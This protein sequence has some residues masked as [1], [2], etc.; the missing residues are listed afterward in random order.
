MHFSEDDL[1]KAL[2]RQDPGSAFT[3]RVMAGIDRAETKAQA[4]FRPY[5]FFSRMFPL[6]MRP[7]LGGA[8]AALVLLTGGGA[9]YW[10][11]QQNERKKQQE[12][13]IAKQA[14]RQAVLA[15]RIANAKLNRVFQRVRESQ[16]NEVGTRREKL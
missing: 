6:R 8:L 14:E 12:L 9:G 13:V 1:L 10:Q 15:L 4:R 2:R 7:A 5:R 16:E 3:R 11:Y